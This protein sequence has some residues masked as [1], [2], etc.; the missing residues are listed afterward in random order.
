MKLPTVTGTIRRRLL[1]NFRVEAEV[2]ARELPPR[3]A[4][5]LHQGHAIAGVCLI[6]LEGIRPPGVPRALGISSENAAHR[7]AITWQSSDGPKEG[8]FIPRRDTDSLLN[9]MAGGRLFPGEHHPAEFVVADDGDDISL[10]MRATDGSVSVRVAASVGSELPPSSCFGSVSEASSFFEPGSL[11]YS[12]TSA[13]VKLH[14]VELRTK[15][16]RVE[17]LIVRDVYSSYFSDR[18]RFPEGAVS[19]D[20][21]LVMR[22]IEHEWRGAE[23][24][25][26]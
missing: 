17:P 7:I 26:I 10:S 24:L 12:A 1:L 2:I 14:G 25:Y 23:D 6:R 16:W 18:S 19:F 20:H 9:Q 11:G 4:P 5:K 8:V 21:G 3:F 22:S 15:S 13:G